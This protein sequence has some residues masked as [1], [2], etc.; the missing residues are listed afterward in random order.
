MAVGKTTTR[1][2]TGIVD[3]VDETIARIRAVNAATCLTA[4]AEDPG[5][6]ALDADS[7]AAL[8]GVVDDLLRD[9]KGAIDDLHD[10]AVAADRARAA[11]I[12]RTEIAKLDVASSAN[13][14]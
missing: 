13:I 6:G 3:S 11:A 2:A 7:L 14:S 4:S 8:R 12:M 5:V 9:V 10:L 1:T